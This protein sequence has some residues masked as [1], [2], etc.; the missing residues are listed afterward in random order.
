MIDPKL[1]LGVVS[2]GGGLRTYYNAGMFY[3]LKKYNYNIRHISAASGG[4]TAGALPYLAART[5]EDI[6]NYIEK[7]IERQSVF[8]MKRNFFTP[9]WF[10]MSGGYI[11]KLDPTFIEEEL[12]DFSGRETFFENLKKIRLDISVTDVTDKI[13]N[14]S[15]HFNR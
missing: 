2:S 5:E 6:E 14:I 1:K 11:T 8:S 9:D 13:E 7:L 15:V 3:M 12:M 10:N 4:A